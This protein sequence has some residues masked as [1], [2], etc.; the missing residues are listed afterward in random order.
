[1]SNVF[2]VKIE[3]LGEI[4]L[5]DI[6]EVV[7]SNPGMQQQIIDY[8]QYQLEEQGLD[9]EAVPT[10]EYAPRTVQM[11]IQKGQRY[12]HITLKDTGDFFDSMKLKIQDKAARIQADMKKPDQDLEKQWPDALGLT[13]DS[14]EA[15]RPLFNELFLEEY[16][17]RVDTI[18]YGRS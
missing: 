12:D 3:S 13:P 17:N 6:F 11:K 8:N 5:E 7:M 1:M 14:I 9:A 15:I 4:D 18:L 16:Q 2:E 10:G